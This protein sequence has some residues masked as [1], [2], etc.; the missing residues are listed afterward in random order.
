MSSPKISIITPTFNSEKHIQRC[1]KNITNQTYVNK[2]HW[3]IDGLSNDN[4][5][6]IIQQESKQFSHIY[7]VH[8]KDKGV[9][10]AMN[11][12]IQAAT[13]EWIFF[14]GND[15]YLYDTHVLETIATHIIT[16]PNSQIIYGNVW[17]EKYKCI[18]DGEFNIEKILKRNICHQ[19][20]FYHRS[21]FQQIGLFNLQYPQEADYEFN[22]RCWFNNKITHTYVPATIAFYADGGVSSVE[23]DSNLV[24]D[25]P[26][27]IIE[28]A[29]NNNWSIFKR[30][31]ILSKSFRKILLRYYWNI[32]FKL[33]I[34]KKF[35]IS[36]IAAFIWMF[37]TLPFY[38]L[39]NLFKK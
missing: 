15:D 19:A 25:Y 21:V 14:L 10:D 3:C 5:I 1:I 9:Y 27:K 17:Y 31:D 24:K 34:R 28:L 13:G 38:F 36:R 23:R 35:F 2:E 29:L 39:R 26:A 32:F 37:I 12:G 20:I 8:E 30:I 7:Y 16:H 6:S 18:Y 22:L 4:T 33:L 11:K